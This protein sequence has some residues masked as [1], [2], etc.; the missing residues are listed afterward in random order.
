MTLKFLLFVSHQL[1]IHS[2]ILKDQQIKSDIFKKNHDYNPSFDVQGR[3]Y[4]EVFENLK[5]TYSKTSKFFGDVT[6]SLEEIYEKGN[7]IL[8]EGAQGTLLDVDYGTYPYVTSSNTLAT[9]V[10]VGSGF[11]KSIYANV[12]GVVKAYTTRVGEG[13]FPTELHNEYG[14][15]NA[16]LLY[17]SPSPRDS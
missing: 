13:P 10:G 6:D 12:L 14:E 1:I 8:Y 15:K 9:S 4:Q 16:C 7:H 17:T 3:L 11:P 5:E 2:L